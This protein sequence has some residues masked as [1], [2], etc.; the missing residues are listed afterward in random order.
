[1]PTFSKKR[2]CRYFLLGSLVFP[3]FGQTRVVYA[4]KVVGP[5]DIPAQFTIPS[6]GPTNIT[7]YGTDEA[8]N[9]N[10]ALSGGN[11][12][13]FIDG[14]FSLS[15]H[16]TLY[17]NTW[18]TVQ[19]GC[20]LIMRAASNDHMFENAHLQLA[21]SH[22]THGIDG[23]GFV[24]SNFG[25]FNI[26]I[27]GE[28]VLDGNSL[29]AATGTNNMESP[30]GTWL[31]IV[32]MIGV[33]TLYVGGVEM[34]D[35]GTYTAFQENTQNVVW[36]HVFVHQPLP[37]DTAKHTDGIHFAGPNDSIWVRYCHLI[38][39]DDAVALNADDGV[40]AGYLQGGDITNAWIIGN[41]FDGVRNAANLMSSASWIDQVF[42]EHNRGTSLAE[43]LHGNPPEVS[44]QGGSPTG[45][46]D[47]GVLE[48]TDWDVP[49]ISTSIPYYGGTTS[50]PEG[51]IW[52]QGNW[53]GIELTGIYNES[54]QDQTWPVIMI[55]V[56]SGAT[57]SQLGISDM[58]ITSPSGQ[59][60]PAIV[61]FNQAITNLNAGSLNWRD[62]SSENGYFFAGSVAPTNVSLGP[63]TGPQ[64]RELGLDLGP[65]WAGQA[66]GFLNI[67][68]DNSSQASTI[69]LRPVS[70]TAWF[71]SADG[72]TNSNT[73][74]QNKFALGDGTYNH[75][76]VDGSGD[77]YVGGDQT[78]CSGTGAGLKITSAGNV[79]AAACLQIGTSG[80]SWCQGSGE[81]SSTPAPG[82]LYSRTD[83]GELYVYQGGTWVAK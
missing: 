74:C 28:G 4:S 59:T 63:Y 23:E 17:S 46:G 11:V 76:V 35:S 79:I 8:A 58:E 52:F 43:A 73:T 51:D 82:S 12:H 64:S 61:S 38:T 30:S 33:Q 13:L 56:L 47:Y 24:V 25:D 16:L 62:Q 48:V 14:Q 44:G 41:F 80:A 27:D 67:P 1:M 39:G 22:S 71:M 65:A 36:D 45:N 40:I 83:T 10:A 57:I 9:L 32:R 81:P 7:T 5:S 72:S 75:F 19:A 2:L 37:L 3:A 55:G 54:F 69:G 31:Y 77:S 42:I 68:I 60:R 50:P 26:R 49:T 78:N 18:I 21:T 34:F 15:A 53:Q 70:S 20:G 29:N 66:A 6:S